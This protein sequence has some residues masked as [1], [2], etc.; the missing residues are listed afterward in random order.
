[1]PVKFRADHIGSFL[2]PPDLLAARAAE[3]DPA[4]LQALEDRE[5]LADEVEEVLSGELDEARA[6]KDV[7]MDVVDSQRKVREADFGGVRL[8]LHLCGM[9]GRKRGW[10]FGHSVSAK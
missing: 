2:R 4:R 3:T 6:E 5:V 10:G 1:M 9:G 8:Q 7:I